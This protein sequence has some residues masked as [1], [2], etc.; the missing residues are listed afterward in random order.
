MD[1]LYNKSKEA[2]LERSKKKLGIRNNYDEILEEVKNKDFTNLDKKLIELKKEMQ[3][4]AVNLE[5]EK[6]KELRDVVRKL[7]E[8]RL[9]Y[10]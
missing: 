9:I 8:A 1:D 6:A 5:F 2:K 10:E 4:A 7:E 3:K